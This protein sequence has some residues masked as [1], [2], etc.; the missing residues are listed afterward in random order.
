MIDLPLPLPA[1]GTTNKNKNSDNDDNYYEIIFYNNKNMIKSININE[2]L[3]NNTITS[4]INSSRNSDLKES[5]K[6]NGKSKSL[7]KLKQIEDMH[8]KL[9]S[10]KLLTEKAIF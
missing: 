2:T 10:Y 7:I 3:K 6:S 8:Q 5:S 4:E 1:W 9:L